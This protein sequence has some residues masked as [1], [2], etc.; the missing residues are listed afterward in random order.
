MYFS[1]LMFVGWQVVDRCG[2]D[3]SRESAT[4]G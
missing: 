2:A 1:I 4:A 3:R